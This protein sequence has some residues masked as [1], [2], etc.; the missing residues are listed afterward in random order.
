MEAST[1]VWALASVPD[2][3]DEHL[4]SLYPVPDDVGRNG[5]QFSVPAQ[6]WLS[7]F[8]KSERLSPASMSRFAMRSAAAGLNCPRYA[9]TA[10]TVRSASGIHI[11][12][13][14]QAAALLPEC[15]RSSARRPPSRAGSLCPLQS[16]RRHAHRRQRPLPHH[17][18]QILDDRRSYSQ[19]NVTGWRMKYPSG[20]YFSC[21][22]IGPAPG[23]SHLSSQ[24]WTSRYH[25]MLFCGF[26]IQWFSSG[27]ITRRDGML[28][29]WSA[30]NMPSDWL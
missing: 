22:M 9:R 14:I 16:P 15:P 4:V 30:L 20:R 6:G 1:L 23:R 2:T 28:R 25:W 18:R 29:R 8:G 26:R 21:A 3:G 12:P 10:S 27:Y 24:P 13:A 17:P 19:L 7:R 11:T 5:R